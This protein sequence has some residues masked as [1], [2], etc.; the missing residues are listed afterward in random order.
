MG[1]A[2][3]EDEIKLARERVR[4]EVDLWPAIATSRLARYARHLEGKLASAEAARNKAWEEIEEWSCE[5]HPW[6]TAS[7]DPLCDPA[8]VREYTDQAIDAENKREEAFRDMEARAEKAER[9][10]ESLWESF[11]LERERYEQLAHAMEVSGFPT[12][13]DLNACGCS[14]CETIRA[15]MVEAGFLEAPDGE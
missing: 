6:T 4:M 3:T 1:K 7:G 10:R 14:I 13:A 8:K 15:S 12:H 9:E 11:R 2:M 5:S